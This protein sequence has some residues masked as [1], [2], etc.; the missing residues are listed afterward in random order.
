MV[1][2]F[3]PERPPRA[4]KCQTNSLMVTNIKNSRLLARQQYRCHLFATELLVAGHPS[5]VP[6]TL[7]PIVVDLAISAASSPY[8][9][10]GVLAVARQAVLTLDF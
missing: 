5:L 2:V 10:F 7:M 6:E 4:E 3:N 9:F 1:V 8:D